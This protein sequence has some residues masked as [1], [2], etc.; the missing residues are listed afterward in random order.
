MSLNSAIIKTKGLKTLAYFIPFKIF[1]SNA[2]LSPEIKNDGIMIKAILVPESNI[3]A[4]S[5]DM[6]EKIIA[7][8][9]NAAV[10]GE[11]MIFHDV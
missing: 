5:K 11:G 8:T 2:E 7:T 10:I 4:G 3:G 1:G 6:N 9:K